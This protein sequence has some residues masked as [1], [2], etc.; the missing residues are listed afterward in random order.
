[1]FMVG[2]VTTERPEGWYIDSTRFHGTNMVSCEIVT[3]IQ[4]TTIIRAYL[5]PSNMDRLPYLKEALN[6][7]LGK[8]TIVM[9]T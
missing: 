4:W 2:L 5:P 1:M 9:R 6:H 3:G 7:L 8:D